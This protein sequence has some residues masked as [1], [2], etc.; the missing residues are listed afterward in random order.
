[1]KAKGTLSALE[2]TVCREI[3]V[4]TTPLLLQLKGVK[5]WIEWLALEF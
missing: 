5:E 3:I 4:C 1:M 2:Q